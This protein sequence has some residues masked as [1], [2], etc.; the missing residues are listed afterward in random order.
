MSFP[1]AAVRWR[2]SAGLLIAACQLAA[3][4]GE[5]TLFRTA[6]QNTGHTGLEDWRQDPHPARWSDSSGL[7]T[8]RFGEVRFEARDG[9]QLVALVYRASRFD[10]ENG[11]IWFVMHGASSAAERYI[12]AAAPV[13]ERYDALAIAIHFPKSVYPSGSD[14]TLGLVTAGRP[15]SN[16][17]ADGRW[18]RPEA[19]LYAEVEHV[20]EA[21]RRSIGGQQRGYYLFGHSAG[22]QF[23]HRLM[24]F[25]PDARV[26]GAVAANA[27]WYTLPAGGEHPDLSMPYGLGGTPIEPRDLRPFFA[28]SH[29]VLL[30]ERDTNTPATD[31]LVRGTDEAMAQGATCLQRGKFY[32]ATA[33]AQAEAL[34][35]QFNWRLAIVPRAGHRASQMMSS[36]GF[37]LFMPNELPCRASSAADARGLVITEILADPPRGRRG[38]ANGDGERDA[39]ADEFV[40][41][42]NGGATPVCLSGWILGDAKDRERHVFPLGRALAPGK[43]LVVFGGGVPTGGFGG[44][45]V[46]WAAFG[47][48]L[49]LSNKGDVLTLQ[50][51][52]NR[53]VRQ[54]SWGDCAGGPCA[55][56]H[57]ARELGIA[58]SIIRWPEPGGTWAA[59]AR[60][61]PADYSPGV[62]ADGS[63]W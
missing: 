43:A 53:T 52:G 7:F 24:T 28:A 15:D 17:L 4:A 58:G 22:A 45:D 33:Q 61:A 41:I 19:Y 55:T 3:Y 32:F 25:L 21:G 6:D 63:D 50:D 46:Q 42:F 51:A 8:P 39:A 5:S 54:I 35:E 36:A 30:G 9:N 34:N 31:R 57:L 18:R 59:H 40:E 16:A 1:P 48:R 2:L 11:P 49:S 44:A 13:A 14:H 56:E 29:V 10:P 60:V 27:G 47:K 62:R 26:L 20:F 12:R 37:F 38:D 23:T